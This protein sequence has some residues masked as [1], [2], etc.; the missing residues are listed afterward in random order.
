MIEPRV[1]AAE[2]RILHGAVCRAEGLVAVFLLHVLGDFETAQRLRSATEASR[3][4][5][6]VGSPYHVIG[7]ESLDE[8]AH[9]RRSEEQ[10]GSGRPGEE[11][12]QVAVHVR[13]AVLPGDLGQVGDPFNAA[14]LLEVRPR[15][16]RRVGPVQRQPE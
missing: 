9:D 8:R 12:P 6:R 4:T 5:P 11:L 3:S 16:F 2:V 15:R 14:G 10:V 1:V 13:D 7:A